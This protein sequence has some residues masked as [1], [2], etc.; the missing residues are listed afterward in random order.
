M[1]YPSNYGGTRGFSYYPSSS[2]SARSPHA[3]TM[4]VNGRGQVAAK[5]D[6]ALF[7]I[8]VETKSPTVQAAQQENSI[9]SAN[10]IQAIKQ[11]GIKEDHIRTID[12][13][14]RPEYEIVDGTSYLKGYEVEHLLEVTVKDL[15]KIG[16]V[17]EVAVKSGANIARN[18]Q[19]RVASP[20]LYYQAALKLAV[21]DAREKA[22]AI[23]QT[24]GAT[25]H[26]IPLRI[27]EEGTADGVRPML[28]AASQTS[29]DTAPPIQTG[30]LTIHA[31]IKA[32]FE[33]S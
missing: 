11:T 8:G 18:I 28:F 4:T 21:Q 7:I 30:E 19:L 23:A 31:A 14:I 1:F 25:V 10:V 26:S 22:A 6:E 17:Y 33:Y 29:P 20:H 3:Y 32:V 2:P 13:T 9:V 27:A 24:I 5:P 12:Y 16:T 15:S